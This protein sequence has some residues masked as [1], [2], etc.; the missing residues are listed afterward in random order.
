MRGHTRRMNDS[1]IETRNATQSVAARCD[2]R[3]G[4]ALIRTGVASPAEPGAAALRR[5]GDDREAMED[6]V[7]MSME[8]AALV[9]VEAAEGGHKVSGGCA[10]RQPPTTRE[11]PDARVA[12]AADGSSPMG[13]CWYDPAQPSMVF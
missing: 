8:A 7:Q 10:R 5:H 6:I 3:N 11:L 9:A 1:D 12:Q 13:T 4:T 2:I